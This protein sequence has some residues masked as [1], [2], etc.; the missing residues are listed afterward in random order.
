[1]ERIKYN[2]FA[3]MLVGKLGMQ[4]EDNIKLDVRLVQLGDDN[5]QYRH[6]KMDSRTLQF[7]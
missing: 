6:H 7:L 2:V 3:G 5:V 4:L 1:M